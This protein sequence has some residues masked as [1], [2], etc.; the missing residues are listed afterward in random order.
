VSSIETTETSSDV[1][2][3]VRREAYKKVVSAWDWLREKA[4]KQD[5]L[6]EY[7]Q[8]LCIGGKH[9][10][11]PIAEMVMCLLN[12]TEPSYRQLGL[13]TPEG[14][15]INKMTEQ[16]LR[17]HGDRGVD[18][19]PYLRTPSGE[20]RIE[21]TDAACYLSGALV[22]LI[23]YDELDDG[24]KENCQRVFL[25]TIDWLNQ[26]RIRVPAPGTK[27]D[28]GKESTEVFGWSWSS[29]EEAKRH[30]LEGWLPPQTYFTSQVMTTLSEAVFDVQELLDKEKLQE[31][32]RSIVGAKRFLLL[33][34]KEQR[35]AK[36]FAGWPDFDPELAT[37]VGA[38]TIQPYSTLSGSLEYSPRMTLYGLEALTY[39]FYYLR[40]SAYIDA[41]A[42][43]K[44]D[45]PALY[46]AYQDF[47][48]DDLRRLDKAFCHAASLVEEANIFDIPVRIQ[49][50]EPLNLD[51][52]QES[53]IRGKNT[54]LLESMYIDGTA[55]Y[56]LLNTLNFYLRFAEATGENREFIEIWRSEE[57][58]FVSNICEKCHSGRSFTH[59]AKLEDRPE[60]VY[61]T[62]TAVA[63]LLSWGVSPSVNVPPTVQRLVGELYE[64]V[65]L[66]EEP[67]TLSDV[68]RPS[69]SHAVLKDVAEMGF[70]VGV[71]AMKLW[72]TRH[73][74]SDLPEYFDMGSKPSGGK[75]EVVKTNGLG[76]LARLSFILCGDEKTV[77]EEL[78]VLRSS[79]HLSRPYKRL[80]G[81]LP[82][83]L[84][85][86]G[87]EGRIR[88]VRKVLGALRTSWPKKV[89]PIMEDM[90]NA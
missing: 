1:V 75:Q 6:D 60:V 47:S 52:G 9:G 39:V 87:L 88:E 53:A 14:S 12:P 3:N 8:S 30:S 49:V 67:K 42:T 86:M 68:D 73:D 36:Q 44:S 56:N 23:D 25:E 81:E 4:E 11:M 64:L 5:Y 59:A 29:P 50:A 28:G 10:V 57:Y 16:L 54:N 65:C 15:L 38:T 66:S 45:S 70:I 69:L 62:R 40:T 84:G 48:S 83:N 17:V 71:F 51:E 13:A 72:E 37:A 32:M 77:R 43:L 27:N 18:G 33:T 89:R 85:G 79:P 63:S 74:A 22:K 90:L 21:F 82:D 2:L 46:S 78:A 7:T 34:L 19:A 76:L 35:P 55:M 58:N 61:A 24:L 20:R 31:T 26:A 41:R 80:V